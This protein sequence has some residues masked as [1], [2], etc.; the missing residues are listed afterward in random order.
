VRGRGRLIGLAAVA[1]TAAALAPASAGAS[2]QSDACQYAKQGIATYV[3]NCVFT[4]SPWVPVK[5]SR[6][7]GWRVICPGSAPYNY[8][9]AGEEGGSGRTTDSAALT[10]V[11]QS[12]LTLGTTSSSGGLTF[13]YFNWSFRSTHSFQAG[14]GCSA[15][16][17]N[18]SSSSL[19]AR[20]AQV[21]GRVEV[22]RHHRLRSNRTRTV[23]RRCPG[24]KQ[25]VFARHGVGYYTKR[26]PRKLAHT[27]RVSQRGGVVRWRMK[28]GRLPA[29]TVLQTIL[30][31]R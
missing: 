24:S 8:A 27:E 11:E 4:V 23:T 21:G 14:I 10:F 13:S 25:L 6:G 3:P 5:H 1:A 7:A 15:T 2:V 22:V 29:K 18:P 17:P 20:V 12:G 28:T 19:K 31:C 16:N 26:P 9:G 30:V